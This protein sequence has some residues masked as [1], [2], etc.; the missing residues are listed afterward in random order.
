[1]E[2]KPKKLIRGRI[3]EKLQPNEFETIEDQNELNRLYALKIKEELAEIQASEHKDI[4]EF[5]DLIQVVFAF[6]KANGISD[7]DLQKYA[8][9][10]TESKGNF[11]NI[12]LNNLNP[13][14]PSNA[15][16][17]EKERKSITNK[18]LWEMA[19]TITEKQQKTLETKGNIYWNVLEELWFEWLEDELLN[20]K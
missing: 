14:N 9:L 19:K 10:K 20:D 3:T 17:F 8:A 4:M 6:A 15:L 16:Y 13:E 1:M 11:S 2:N 18:K 12:A 7:Y 5:V